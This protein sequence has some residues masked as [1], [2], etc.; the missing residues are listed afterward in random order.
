MTCYLWLICINLSQ[1]ASLRTT[2]SVLT[3]GMYN[4]LLQELGTSFDPLVDLILGSLAKLAGAT[5]KITAENSQ[6]TIG[7]IIKKTTCPTKAFISFLSVGVHE[8]APQV[9]GYYAR[10]LKEYLEKHNGARAPAWSGEQLGSVSEMLK[11]LIGDGT[12][13]VRETARQAF[14]QF[15]IKYPNEATFLQNSLDDGARKLLEKAKPSP[16]SATTKAADTVPDDQSGVPSVAAPATKMEPMHALPAATTAR[17][18]KPVSNLMAEMKKKKLAAMRAQ[19]AMRSSQE[20]MLLPETEEKITPSSSTVQTPAASPPV[21]PRR[22]SSPKATN[23]PVL[24]RPNLSS[25]TSQRSSPVTPQSSVISKVQSPAK[26]PAEIPLP[27]TPTLIDLESKRIQRSPRPSSPPQPAPNPFE[28]VFTAPTGSSLINGIQADLA[29]LDFGSSNGVQPIPSTS[30][31]VSVS[32]DPI[33]GSTSSKVP[34]VPLALTAP[35]LLEGETA[36]TTPNASV[37]IPRT[38]VR[39]ASHSGTS[40]SKVLNGRPVSTEKWDAAAQSYRTPPFVDCSLW[41]AASRKA[42][43][44]ADHSGPRQTRLIESIEAD[45]AD[46]RISASTL[47]DAFALLRE[48]VTETVQTM[49]NIRDV[50]AIRRL[51]TQEG[52]ERSSTAVQT[53]V[54][55]LVETATRQLD[56][57]VSMPCPRTV[58]L[59]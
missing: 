18:R 23:S 33:R 6:N 48:V 28:D 59:T 17:E 51:V 12:P 8:K 11:H 36:T 24:R 49:T 25:S 56:S 10:H 1:L 47:R 43:E 46:R 37:P 16:V 50:D 27:E 58:L 21:S 34:V 9:R 44:G 55:N 13:A 20:D 42:G 31:A 30:A 14:W 45:I 19:A 29:N 54:A 7:L 32:A 39:T 53:I 52:D 26:V 3:I 40:G 35:S 38:A 57:A 15:H 4:D 22:A 2:L 5:K 41:L